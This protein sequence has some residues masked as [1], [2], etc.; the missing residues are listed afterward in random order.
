MIDG[1]GRPTRVDYPDGSHEAFGYTANGMSGGEAILNLT[2]ERDREGNVS[3][4]E[5]N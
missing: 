2:W 3:C 1:L 5:P 4:Y